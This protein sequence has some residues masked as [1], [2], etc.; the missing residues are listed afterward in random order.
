M[1]DICSQG[2][3]NPVMVVSSL[4]GQS[5]QIR[6]VFLHELGITGMSSELY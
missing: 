4:H 1:E 5:P 2:H 6:I 3:H